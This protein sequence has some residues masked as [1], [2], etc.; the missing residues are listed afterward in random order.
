[1]KV[2]IEHMADWWLGNLDD[3]WFKALENAVRNEWAVEPLNIRE[4]GVES[5][6]LFSSD[7]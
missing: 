2:K 1:M 3:P 6:Y 7:Y 5:A 4:G